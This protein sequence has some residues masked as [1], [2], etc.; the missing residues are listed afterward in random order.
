[1]EATSRKTENPARVLSVN[2]SV[3]TLV[4]TLQT[5]AEKKFLT[6]TSVENTTE[7]L[8]TRNLPTWAIASISELVQNEQWE[9]LN[10]RF[11]KSLTFG[12]AGIRGRTVGTVSTKV[13][14]QGATYIRAAVGSACMNDFNVIAVTLAL[15]KYCEKTLRANGRFPT[16]PRLVI[17]YDSRHFSEHFC[18]LTASVWSACGG[19]V[20]C[21]D[22]PRST[23]QLSFSVRW[24][25]ATAGVMITASHNPFYDNG[26]KVYGS[27]GA[28]I[29]EAQ[30]TAVT[31]ELQTVA[32]IDT[33]PYLDL[34]YTENVFY[35]SQKADDAYL[36]TCR[37]VLI[38]PR[39]FRDRKETRIVYTP[40]HGT[41]SVCILSLL[42]EF[43]WKPHLVA[44]QLPMDGAFP[45]VASPNPDNRETLALALRDAERIDADAVIATDPDGDRMSMMMKDADGRWQLLNG[46][47]IAILL[48]EYRYT[49][50]AKDQPT[51]RLAIL[52]SYVTTPL[53]NAFAEKNNLKCVETHT[54][55]KW[56]GAKLKKYEEQ[57]KE[58]LF[59]DEGL[60]LDYKNCTY[61]ARRRLLG[62]HSSVLLLGAEESCGFLANDA[63]R[64]KDANAA[65]LMACELVAYL[66]S[67][68]LTFT[69]YLD[70][71]Y[72]KYGYFHEDLLSFTFEGAA[73]LEKIKTL[74][75]S[76]RQCPPKVFGNAPVIEIIDFLN[77][78]K[79]K[80]ADGDAVPPSNFMKFRL[81]NDC[82]VAVRPSG[83][84]P[85]IKFYLF[86]EGKVGEGDD[87]SRIKRAVAERL[88]TL[89]EVLKN[90]VSGRTK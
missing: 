47:T 31:R 12:T 32:L 20:Y 86:G 81:G 76:Y 30:A 16:N 21:F 64:D 60:C 22:S 10:N 73:G 51:E 39:Q 78:E 72:R 27:D 37:D 18:E 23:P 48:A 36:S 56:I 8:R 84:E 71:I 57:A 14:K 74:M 88:N 7:F 42:K 63:V 46:N 6:D 89:K 75:H 19:E 28:Q 43:S 11:Y 61:E 62:Q 45:T 67:E 3:E 90:D 2:T 87:L 4:Q 26:Y 1:M 83:T 5:A 55:F 66:K 38:N 82:T 50:V 80:D 85:K 69:E 58:A 33:L 70:R 17:A 52:K 53:L 49:H 77:T 40:L 54:G 29:D 9:E 41:G 13:E 25:G 34:L 59:R 15:F 44:E 79:M 65:T 68:N 35:L 24:L